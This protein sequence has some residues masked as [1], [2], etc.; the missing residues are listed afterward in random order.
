MRT[1]ILLLV[2]E[3]I[4]L[5]VT[6]VG[7]AACACVA[8]FGS[9]DFAVGVGVSSAMASLILILAV[10]GGTVATAAGV[11]PSNKEHHP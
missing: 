5:A 6:A 8:I 10:I 3:P 2:G 9:H 7:L 11:A 4:R 1:V